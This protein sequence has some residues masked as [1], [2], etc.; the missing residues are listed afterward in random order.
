MARLPVSDRNSGPRPEGQSPMIVEETHLMTNHT[1]VHGQRE[2]VSTPS[3]VQTE[4]RPSS[5]VSRMLQRVCQAG[6][7][8]RACLLSIRD[9]SF[10]FEDGFDMARQVFQNVM[11]QLF[12]G[13]DRHQLH[14][15][16]LGMKEKLCL[17]IEMRG[18]RPHR[19]FV[20]TLFEDGTQI[21]PFMIGL[22]EGIAQTWLDIGSAQLAHA[23]RLIEACS[24]CD[25]LE[26]K[27]GWIRWDEFLENTLKISVSHKLCDECAHDL[28]DELL[29]AVSSQP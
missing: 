17:I 15:I 3:G 16:V 18:G 10:I 22:M 13:G 26:T 5:L 11:D 2:I 24:V 29:P 8:Q 21:T 9:D 7:A 4:S 20:M 14:K 27:Q 23:P 28:Y 1:Q 19:K 6:G 12:W 25:R